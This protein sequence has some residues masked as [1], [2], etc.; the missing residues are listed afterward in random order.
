MGTPV[1]ALPH[2]RP[3]FASSILHS[4]QASLLIP[5]RCWAR[6]PFSA[7]AAPTEAGGEDHEDQARPTGPRVLVAQLVLLV[8]LT[9]L[10][11]PC[12]PFARL[13]QQLRDSSSSNLGTSSALLHRCDS[14]SSAL[15]CTVP[16]PACHWQ[17]RVRPLLPLCC[18]APCAMEQS[19]TPC[20]SRI[21]SPL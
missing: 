20:A 15:Y 13:T 21:L 14:P 6:A 12:V 18:V 8:F 2:R 1:L 16:T 3:S 9:A 17:S 11:H 4:C 10:D 19:S 7:L 5:T